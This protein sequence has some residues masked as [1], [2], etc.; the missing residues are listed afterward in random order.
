MDLHGNKAYKWWRVHLSLPACNSQRSRNL[1]FK[2]LISLANGLIG[3]LFWQ[4]LS[5]SHPL[6]LQICNGPE[7]KF[8]NFYI[9]GQR[10]YPRSS[11]AGPLTQSTSKFATDKKHKQKDYHLRQ[12]FSLPSNQMDSLSL[13]KSLKPSSITKASE[14]G[15][16]SIFLLYR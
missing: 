13:S 2:N 12:K 5:K 7:I 9:F 10:S 6:Y 3:A 16:H 11:L 14:S 15:M 1:N 8:Q 4:A